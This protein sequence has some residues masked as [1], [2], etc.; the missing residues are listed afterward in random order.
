MTKAHIKQLGLNPLIIH[1]QTTQT[2]NRHHITY[3]A[4]HKGDHV[5]TT[6]IHHSSNNDDRGV[7]RK[8]GCISV[9]GVL[10]GYFWTTCPDERSIF[11][12]KS[13]KKTPCTTSLN[14]LHPNL[15]RF[16]EFFKRIIRSFI[17][18]RK[19]ASHFRE[20]F[21]LSQ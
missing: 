20:E 12:S 5:S 14:N 11:G 17:T 8:P 18:L 21:I 7:I 3:P 15:L 1:S 16:V 2:I 19:L 10:F 9:F 6:V 4:K 13:D